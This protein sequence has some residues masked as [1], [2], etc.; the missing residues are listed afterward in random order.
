M[1]VRH[2]DEKLPFPG[3][4]FDVQGESMTVLAYFDEPDSGLAKI[5]SRGYVLTVPVI[6]LQAALGTD[7]RLDR[8]EVFVASVREHMP[9]IESRAPLTFDDLFDLL[10]TLD[11]GE[12]PTGEN[13]D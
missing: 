2:P 7:R 9:A 10:R 11:E 5:E 12:T 13:D 3:E 1:G 6:L 8:L 4:A